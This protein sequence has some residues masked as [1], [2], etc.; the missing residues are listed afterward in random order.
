MRSRLSDTSPEAQ[1]VLI[2]VY[3]RMPPW[4]KWRQI[5]EMYADA[6]VLHAAG[7]R[8]RQPGATARDVLADWFR[9]SHSLRDLPLLGEEVMEPQPQHL[10]NLPDLRAV[11]GVLERLGIVYALGG[12]M[13]SS[14][15]GVPRYTR[16]ADL[17]VEP[18]SG[19]EA[20]LGSAFGPDYYLSV[21]AMEDANQRRASF[22]IINTMTGFKVDVF[23]RKDDPFEREAFA[24]SQ[25]VAVEP[26]PAAAVR[27]LSAEDTIL[28]K[29]RW[30][31]EGHEVIDE[32]RRDVLNVL[33]VQAGQLDAAY[34]DRWAAYL[35]VAD[36]LEEARAEAD[37]T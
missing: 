26:P 17:T 22:N 7:V 8:H 9:Y 36:L 33:R 16:D 27:M 6:R 34:L 24:R 2:E 11:L 20:E 15:Y 5:G 14:F 3:R 4:R 29:L 30:Y 21:A 31:R 19:R 1:R 37:P 35:G 10:V 13:A 32:Q 12:S 18:F 23:V 28:F 25:S